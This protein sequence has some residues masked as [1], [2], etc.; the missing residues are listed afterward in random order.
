[1]SELTGFLESNLSQAE[2]YSR[3]F[4]DE[5]GQ[6]LSIFVETAEFAYRPKLVRSLRKGG[7][8]IAYYPTEARVI[9]VDVETEAGKQFVHDWGSEPGKAVLNWRWAAKAIELG[10][11]PLSSEDWGGF[12]L[13]RGS[14]GGVVDFEQSV[15][16]VLWSSMHGQL[17]WRRSPLPTPRQT[18]PEAGPS[19]PK[20]AANLPSSSQQNIAALSIAARE[21]VAENPFNPSLQNLSN[22]HQQAN[23]ML[24]MAAPATSTLPAPSQ[25]PPPPT[26]FAETAAMLQLL[27]QSQASTAMAS[28]VLASNPPPALNQ[29]Q[30]LAS[31]SQFNQ[32]PS[33]AASDFM[34]V[35]TSN[36]I[37]SHGSSDTRGSSPPAPQVLPPSLK[38]K[39][40]PYGVPSPSK[41]KER[42]VS[43]PRPTKTLRTGTP[44]PDD[45][46]SAVMPPLS[47]QKSF[48]GSPRDPGNALVTDEGES[49]AIW[50]QMETRKRSDLLQVIKKNGGRIVADVLDADVA[51]LARLTKSFEHWLKLA[52]QAGT[53]AVRPQYI[54][55]CIS[56]SALLKTEPYEYEY[57]PEKRKRG[58]P[59]KN[60]YKE[61]SPRKKPESKPKPKS[62]HSTTQHQARVNERMD[63]QVPPIHT[64]PSPPPPSRVVQWTEGKN[65]YTQEEMEY[66]EKYGAILLMREPDMPKGT[67]AAKMHH[68]MPQHS[69]GSWQTWMIKKNAEIDEWR[70][71]GFVAQRKAS[72][73]N[74]KQSSTPPSTDVVANASPSA[75]SRMQMQ[76][77]IHGEFEV[78]TEF[79]ARGG[80]DNRSDDEVWNELARRYP[81]L[82]PLQWR[83]YWN[84]HGREVNA[85]V[86]R[87]MGLYK[88]ASDQKT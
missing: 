37:D 21:L 11:A 10:R 32:S 59:S 41:G 63:N 49:T 6:E 3:V 62:Q 85:E 64:E 81:S 31:A 57:V 9:L 15:H 26:P 29:D 28:S 40:S 7:A 39:T 35:G 44:P 19:Q 76:K 47:S 60:P 69:L 5:T 45:A 80:A 86:E 13:K 72:H 73:V 83:D 53:P 12:R 16:A 82:T 84:T 25:P 18:P 54:H 48:S 33:V 27:L 46:D 17:M 38:R 14:D 8:R 58:R 70:K 71:R 66:F 88:Q 1:M 52:H 87:L 2:G 68:K 65:F 20:A 61:S 50:V 43:P 51:V 79:L 56:D 23:P 22:N 74:E 75:T 30:T 78:M 34:D 77:A 24:F 42:A 55:D 4:V 36:V 67:L